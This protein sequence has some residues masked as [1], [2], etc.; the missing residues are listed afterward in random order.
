MIIND[1]VY[2]KCKEEDDVSHFPFSHVMDWVLSDSTKN[3][4]SLHDKLHL[5]LDKRNLI[6]LS[7]IDKSFKKLLFYKRGLN[8]KG[9]II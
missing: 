7:E 3:Q 5:F 6:K 1:I 4:E 2:G 9:F 8:S